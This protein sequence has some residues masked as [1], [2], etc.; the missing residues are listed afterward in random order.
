MYPRWLD[1]K[2]FGCCANSTQ[3]PNFLEIGN[4]YFAIA[5]LNHT[6]VF[7]VEASGLCLTKPASSAT[8]SSD[9]AHWFCQETS[10]D[11]IAHGRALMRGRTWRTDGLHVASCFQDGMLRMPEPGGLEEKK[12][13]EGGAWMAFSGEKKGMGKL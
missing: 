12:M 10:I 5:S 2:E 7:H 11:K 4:A 13:K 3:I 1:D 6:V 8:S 9:Q